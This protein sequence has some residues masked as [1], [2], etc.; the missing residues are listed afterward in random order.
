[1]YEKVSVVIFG[2]LISH[3]L[4]MHRAQHFVQTKSRAIQYLRSIRIYD[5]NFY[6]L[7][8]VSKKLYQA[9][10]LVAYVQI[11]VYVLRKYVRVHSTTSVSM[12]EPGW[13]FPAPWDMTEFPIICKLTSLSDKKKISHRDQARQ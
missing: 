10:L 6:L 5:K 8:I 9:H 2:Q 7:S 4:N 11:V 1:M 13:S 12:L 3:E